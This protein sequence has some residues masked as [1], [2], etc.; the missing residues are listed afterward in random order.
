[1]TDGSFKFDLVFQL[2]S[3][4]DVDNFCTERTQQRARVQ[5]ISSG[6]HK[7]CNNRRFWANFIHSLGNFGHKGSFTDTRSTYAY[8][9]Q[10]KPAQILYPKTHSPL[11]PTLPHVQRTQHTLPK[12]LDCV[13]QLRRQRRSQLHCQ[14]HQLASKCFHKRVWRHLQRNFGGMLHVSC[15][16]QERNQVLGAMGWRRSGSHGALIGDV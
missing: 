10:P 16:F 13:S 9:T 4:I 14:L 3:S 7:S 15:R 12:Q 8:H 6:T 1:M 5:R 11:S 2:R